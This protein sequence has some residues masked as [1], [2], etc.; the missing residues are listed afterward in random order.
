[1]PTLSLPCPSTHDHQNNPFQD[2]SIPSPWLLVRRYGQGC[3]AGTSLPPSDDSPGWRSRAQ[4]HNRGT[5]RDCTF[6]TGDTTAPLPQHHQRHAGQLTAT[7]TLSTALLTLSAVPSFCPTLHPAP[8]PAPALLPSAL[9]HSSPTPPHLPSPGGQGSREQVV[10]PY[11]A[12]QCTHISTVSG[13]ASAQLSGPE[14]A[15]PGQLSTGPSKCFFPQALIILYKPFKCPFLSS[16]HL[17]RHP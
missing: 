10:L 13:P 3:W 7:D 14:E 8:A 4:D 2:S 5:P 9:K 1:M 12:T 15:T 16:T 6:C 11:E 17:P